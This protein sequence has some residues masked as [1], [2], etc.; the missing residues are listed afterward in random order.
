[1]RS[2]NLSA[3]SLRVLLAGGGTAGHVNP[4]L[5]TASALQ[6]LPMPVQLG[7]LGTAQGL[8]SRLVPEAGLDLFHVARVPLPR[9]PSVDLLRVPGRMLGAVRAA[10][11]AI[12]AIDA[13][14]V[15][16]FG[17]Y[18]ATPA[19]LAA[20]RRGVPIVVHEQNALP[21]IANKVGARFAATVALTFPSTPLVASRGRT[22]VTGLPLRA[23]IANLV[24]ERA[25]SGGTVRAREEAA[26]ALGLDASLPTLLVTGGSLGAQRL[27]EVL[28]ASAPNLLA[29][30]VQVLHLT[31]TDKDGPVRAALEGLASGGT[32]VSRYH[33]LPYLT[34]MEQAY[35][36][37]D[38]VICRAGAG[39]VAEVSALGLPALYVPLP[40]GNGEQARNAADV[41]AAG[42]AL[43]VDD[44][45]LTPEVINEQVLPLLTDE[46]GRTEMAA[47]AAGVGPGDGAQSLA[48]LIAVAAQGE[49][50]PAQKWGA[51]P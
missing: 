30:G 40:I 48:A 11:R 25:T 19:Y 22:E 10:E 17:G 44:A 26:A 6:R 43:M 24:R 49:P 1:M 7:V 46:R 34:Q 50:H 23:Q 21:G 28:E 5:A 32:D 51:R 42:G 2:A 4:L 9:R 12:D 41:V 29:S 36:A 37:A 18:V 20:R 38:F 35:A 27:N 8:E 47:R 45:E 33:V 15:V 14:V 31:G 39:T 3:P 13:Q 16:G